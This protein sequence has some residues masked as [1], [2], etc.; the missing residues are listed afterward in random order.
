MQ[1]TIQQGFKKHTGKHKAERALWNISH[2]GRQNPAK[3]SAPPEG[4]KEGTLRLVLW[5][6]HLFVQSEA[7]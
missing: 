7:P 5:G 4:Q 3:C 1:P 2:K 6:C